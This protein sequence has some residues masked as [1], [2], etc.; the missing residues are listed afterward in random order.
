IY[1][2]NRIIPV[3]ISLTTSKEGSD[4]FHRLTITDMTDF[5]MTESL[6][7]DSLEN[8]FLLVH[9]APD[10]IMTVDRVGRIFFAN[11]PAWGYSVNALVGSN[12]LDYVPDSER[13]SVHRCMVESFKHNKRTSCEVGGCDNCNGWYSFSFGFPHA[14]ALDGTTTTTTTTT[15]T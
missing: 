1:V 2:E 5:R 9:N 7:K 10:T 14:T 3:A 15:T 4:I 13:P 12:I 8:W 11:K 6:I